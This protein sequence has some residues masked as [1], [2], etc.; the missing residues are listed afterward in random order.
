[1]P[2]ARAINVNHVMLA[3]AVLV[4]LSSAWRAFFSDDG[5]GIFTSMGFGV[6]L[7]ALALRG[8]RKKKLE[9]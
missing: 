5:L 3:V 2:K 4:L 1:M 7:L 8:L 6:V 9:S